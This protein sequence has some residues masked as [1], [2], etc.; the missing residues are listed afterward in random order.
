MERSETQ[1]IGA[2]TT[3]VYE[4]Q[5]RERDQWPPKLFEHNWVDKQTLGVHV[6]LK[7]F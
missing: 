3:P 4:D 6:S 7:V 1:L 2:D 5:P